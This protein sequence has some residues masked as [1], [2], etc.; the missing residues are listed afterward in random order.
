MSF[1]PATLD[2]L[3]IPITFESIAI[4]VVTAGLLYAPIRAATPAGFYLVK[5]FF[6]YMTDTKFK[7]R[8]PGIV[9]YRPTTGNPTPPGG[10]GGTGGAGVGGGGAGTGGAGVGGGAGGGSF[11][12]R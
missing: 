2:V 8:K 12:G 10:T 6:A 1:T 4:S 3:G 7:S 9:S 5:R 11:G